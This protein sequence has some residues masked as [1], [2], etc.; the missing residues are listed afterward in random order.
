MY[1][2]LVTDTDMPSFEIE[3]E[4]LRPLEATVW[5]APASDEDT[6]VKEASK[7]DAIMVGYAPVREPVIAAAAKAGCKAIVRYGIGYD[8]VDVAAA[9]R[10]G[11]PV[12]NV[13]DYCLDEVADH[14]MAMLL[15]YARGLPQATGSVREGGWD[16]PKGEM[17]RMAGRVLG[18]VGFGRI[19]R[20]VAARALTFGLRVIAYDPVAKIDVAGVE[21]ASSLDDLLAESDYVSIHVPLTKDTRHLINSATLGK[22]RRQPLLIN[23][24]RGGLIDL[25][26][27]VDAL[28]SGRLGGVAL[29]VFETEPLPADHPLRSHPRALI[30]PHMSYYSNESEP[31][32]IRRVA[33]EIARGLRGE[34]LLNPLTK[35]RVA[36]ST[37]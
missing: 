28:Q 19:G 23:T 2:V 22:M 4:V 16:I 30:T 34:P 14:T 21:A 13:P 17:P 33:Q 12:A 29:D 26:A 37:T 18:L 9:E 7:A 11:I 35:V 5:L 1:R 24:A 10:H 25:D 36:A 20:R 31:D 8:N 3:E 15:G 32:L 6:L 27:A